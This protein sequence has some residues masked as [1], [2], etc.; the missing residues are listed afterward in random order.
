MTDNWGVE[1]E[2]REK[3]GIAPATPEP[4]KHS[5]PLFRRD[6]FVATETVRYAL[7]HHQT[8]VHIQDL[9]GHKPAVV[10]GEK[11]NGARHIFGG[12][13]P[14]QRGLVSDGLPDR[15]L[16]MTAGIRRIDQTRSY[17]VDANTISPHFSSQV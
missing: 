6:C 14:S 10:R 1:D 2:K 16:G 5:V 11:E 17:A 8:P 4:A 7:T 9:P 3:T 12:S 15:F 13:D